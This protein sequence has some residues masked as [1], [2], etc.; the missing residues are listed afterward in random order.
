MRAS[1]DDHNCRL[2]SALKSACHEHFKSEAIAK[3]NRC[4]ESETTVT[5]VSDFVISRIVAGPSIIRAIRDRSALSDPHRL[6]DRC[7]LPDRHSLFDCWDL[8]GQD[9][10][11]DRHIR[12]FVVVS[13]IICTSL[14]L[15][16]VVSSRI[17]LICLIVARRLVF[18]SSMRTGRAFNNVMKRSLSDVIDRHFHFHGIR[19]M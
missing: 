13:L 10:L 18:V 5:S 15:V 12:L 16:I 9:D 2:S 8:S 3:P 4:T 17:D 19:D 11:P 6:A 1:Q 7:D 14:L